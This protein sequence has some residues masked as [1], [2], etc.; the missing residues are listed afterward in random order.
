MVLAVAS[1]FEAI[2]RIERPVL[3]IAWVLSAVLLLR[4]A[5]D[6]SAEGAILAA[7]FWGLALFAIAVMGMN[8]LSDSVTRS[9]E[10]VRAHRMR[11][12]LLPFIPIGFLASSLDCSGLSLHGC[13]AFCTFIK[14]V[15]I[16]LIAMGCALYYRT[17]DRRVSSM[18]LVMSFVP[19]MPHCI[20]DNVANGWWI[21]HIGASPEC[22][23]WGFVVSTLVLGA[24]NYARRYVATVAV[25]VAIIGGS[26]GFFV[27]HHYFKFPW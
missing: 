13:S 11:A 6:F 22:Y 27:G 7:M 1:T 3:I 14:L 12:L 5:I 24:L 2:A 10:G 26:F 21:H 23:V 9:V 8:A 16:P 25:S 17:S 15:W 19:L 18:L 20:C 4:F